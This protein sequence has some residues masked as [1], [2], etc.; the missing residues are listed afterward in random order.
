MNISMIAAVGKNNE[1]GK[2]NNLI[3]KLKGDMKFFKNTTMGHMVVMG[4]KTFESL[5]KILPG[6]K[7]IVISR[8]E[9][10]NSEIEI[11]KSIKTFLNTYKDYED[12]VFIIGGASIYKQ[13]M[14][15]AS[16]LYLTEIEAADKEADV[17]FPD[18][19]KEDWDKEYL[20]GLQGD[21]IKYKH[22]LYKRKNL[23][24]KK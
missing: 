17:Y 6:R 7:N 12:E 24:E 23:V 21:S 2:E 22:V 15:L 18:F 19:N 1:L 13:F 14:D 3:W 10:I 16:K 5:P 4:R 8:S 20:S 11:Y 9:I